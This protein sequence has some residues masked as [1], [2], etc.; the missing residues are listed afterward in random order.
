MVAAVSYHDSAAPYG[1]AGDSSAA[2]IRTAMPAVL[3]PLPRC[4][5]SNPFMKM[6]ASPLT[7]RV[8][9]VEA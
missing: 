7:V 3:N 6:L 2:G 4:Y 5:S 1:A 8:N 9:V